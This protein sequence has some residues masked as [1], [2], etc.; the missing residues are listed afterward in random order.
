[1]LLLQI[2][3]PLYG[4]FH[5]SQLHTKAHFCQAMECHLISLRKISYAHNL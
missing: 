1:M 4:S 2:I 3:F 5:N